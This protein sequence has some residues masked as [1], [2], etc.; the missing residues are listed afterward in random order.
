MGLGRQVLLN[1]IRISQSALA[2]GGAVLILWLIS[3]TIRAF[4]LWQAAVSA[5]QVF[6]VAIFLWKSLPIADR[7]PRLS[8]GL[9]RNLW[10]FAAGMSGIALTSLILT[11]IDK[12]LVSKLLSLRLFGYYTLAWVVANGLLV[13]SGAV[14]N[15]I[16]PR[17]SAQVAAGD[18]NGIRQSYHR[19]SQLMAVLVLP[20][21]AILAFFPFEILRLWTRNSETARIAAPIL[22]V[23]VVGSALNAVLFLPYALQLAFGWTKLS[24]I[25]GLSSIALVIPAMFTLTKHFG[26]VGAATVWVALNLVNMIAVVPIMHRRL[27]PREAWGYFRDIGLPL[28]ATIGLTA[29]GRLI[30]RNLTSPATVLAALSSV[31]LGSFAVAVLA[32]PEIRSWALLQLMNTKRKYNKQIG[33]FS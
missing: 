26:A 16:F 27:L 9:V 17:M 32:A 21:A 4:L 14:F 8:F 28:I 11:Q 1:V 18:E 6:L 12:V 25:A 3:P 33:S 23:L 29:L 2:S 10:G 24:L 15:V 31:L 13:I 30:F 7:A 5:A 19:G 20:L 22:G